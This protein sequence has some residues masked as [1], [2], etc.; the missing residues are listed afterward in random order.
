M[1]KERKTAG[2]RTLNRMLRERYGWYVSD[3]YV[4]LN[5][6]EAGIQ[7]VVR[8]KQYQP[9][10]TKHYLYKNLIRNDWSTTQPFEKLC[11]DTT[12]FRHKGT[13]YD[14]TLYIDAFNNE[15]ISYVL[16]TGYRGLDPKAHN[17]AI[18]KVIKEK[19]KRGYRNLETIIHS[20]QGIIY[21]SLA[22]SHAYQDYNIKWSMSRSGTPT[23]NPKIEAIIG[24]IKDE[25]IHNFNLKSTNNLEKLISDYVYY[26]NN[27]RYTYFLKYKSPIQYRTELGFY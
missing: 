9:K 21:T 10:G 8:K 20:D 7:S 1:H 4:H 18:K 3:Y 25:L 15:I 19:I 14:L 13:L 23:D 12:F 2:Y 24:W 11:T 26:F 5:C 22:F 6:K 17:K 27:Q 16:S